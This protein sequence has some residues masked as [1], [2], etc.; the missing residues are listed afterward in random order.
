VYGTPVFSEVFL[1]LL[2]QVDRED[3]FG[4]TPL[5]L[6]ALRGK[7]PVVEF[8]VL[9][10]DAPADRKVSRSFT[11]CCIPDARCCLP[12]RYSSTRYDLV[13]AYKRGHLA[14]G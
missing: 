6:A 14:S 9:D 1:L 10:A 5:H 11:G 2:L 13:P 7:L 8:L 4:Q 12:I 3:E